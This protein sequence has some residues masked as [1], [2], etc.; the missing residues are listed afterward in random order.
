MGKAVLLEA[1]ADGYESEWGQPPPLM[2][3]QTHLMRSGVLLAGDEGV[4]SSLLRRPS[5]YW[6][7][8]QQAL[9]EIDECCP[10]CHFYDPDQPTDNGVRDGT[11]LCR[12]P[13]A[14]RSSL[15]MDTP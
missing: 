1:G 10:L 12:C 11:Y 14:W 8:T 15:H 7:Q 9:D 13:T 2:R 4:L 6:V 3:R 5:S